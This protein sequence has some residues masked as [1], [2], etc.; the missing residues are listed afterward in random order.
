MTEGLKKVTLHL[1]KLFAGHHITIKL[2]KILKPKHIDMLFYGLPIGDMLTFEDEFEKWKRRI[3]IKYIE[4]K[5]LIS[6]C[7]DL[8]KEICSRK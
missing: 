4:V 2:L 6:Q 7:A 5:L 1:R 3:L 8:E